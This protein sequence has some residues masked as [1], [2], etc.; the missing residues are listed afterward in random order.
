MKI[1]ASFGGH[2][3]RVG[4]Q[5]LYGFVEHALRS[6]QAHHRAEDRPFGCHDR[7]A[8]FDTAYPST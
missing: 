7:H 6:R 5:F 4:Q 1:G 2:P 3:A 8:G